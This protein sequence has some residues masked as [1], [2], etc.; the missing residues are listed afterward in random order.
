MRLGVMG[1]TFDPIHYG[2]LLIAEEARR[3]FGLDRVEFVTAAD[4][5]H[6]T[7]RTI[8]PAE[9]RHAMVVLA[10]ASNPFFRASRR[11]LE[12]AGPS[13]SIDTISEVRAESPGAE[14]FFITGADAILEILTWHRAA[15]VIRLCTFVAATR[16]GH[17]LAALQR[18]LPP[19]FVAQIRP[20]KAP[21]VDISGTQIRERVRRGESTRYLMPEAVEAYIMK[22]GLY[23]PGK[24]HGPRASNGEANVE[25]GRSRR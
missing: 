23:R 25:S 19:E 21:G 18:V 4:P 22:E 15:E 6:K 1:G 20:L 8:S 24:G 7:G 10:T 17:D 5:P 13:Y 14:I 2:H 3:V 12:R 9:H 16:P 11:E